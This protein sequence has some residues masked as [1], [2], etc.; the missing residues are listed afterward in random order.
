MN[1]VEI[2][3][4]PITSLLDKVIPDKDK[5]RQ[6]A[7]DVTILVE[8]NVHAQM[9]AQNAVNEAQA[10]HGSIFVAGA[11]PA[12]MWICGAG[13]A[14]NFVIQ[15]IIMWIAFMI[16]QCPVIDGNFVYSQ[17]FCA[18]D[19][20]GAPQL[21]IAELTTI[22][23]GMLGLGTMRSYEKKNGVARSAIVSPRKG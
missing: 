13:L 19:L 8:S 20:S 11:R 2:L 23:L 7:H 17:G 12:I 18:P 4:G 14:W 22:L 21:D 1:L 3:V 6:L 15:P 16:P 5:A 10:Q 9:M